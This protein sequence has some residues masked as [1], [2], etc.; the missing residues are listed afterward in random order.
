MKLFI[1]TY[2]LLLVLTGLSSCEDVID[3]EVQ[4]APERL[5][6]EASLDWAKGTSGN[7]QTIKLS[8]S[9]PFFESDKIK[10][11]TGAI[12]TVTD[13]D[14]G[15]L[16][17]F[18]DQNDG[19]YVVDNFEPVIGHTYALEVVY[20]GQIYQAQET[21]FAVPELTIVGQSREDGF[22]ED[23]LEVNLTLTDPQEEGNSYFFKFWKRGDLLPIFEEFD[24]EFINGN[25]VD[26]YL[27]KE[28]DDE[29]DEKE[30]FQ[31]GD[32]VAIEFYAI[33]PAYKEYLQIMINQIGGVGIFESI[34]VAVKGNC[35]NVTNPDNY[36][37][38]YFRVTEAVKI[39]YTFE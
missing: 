36:A 3:I 5:V 17:N 13:L 9:T 21:L 15:S 2:V 10:I 12:V 6:I 8:K 28:E 31:P 19:N 7:D 1:R 33:S 25:E 29:T 38:G 24:D 34:P 35:I 32:T 30:A 18:Q 22:S 4:N 27:E 26:W 37:H 11:A 16:F 39:D 20:D 14:S 23:D